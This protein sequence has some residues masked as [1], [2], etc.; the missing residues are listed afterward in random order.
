M[1]EKYT[2]D[3]IEVQRI[4]YGKAYDY[5][6]Y[7]A[8]KDPESTKLYGEGAAKLRKIIPKKKRES[9]ETEI[10]NKYKRKSEKGIAD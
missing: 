3:D 7:V 10:D 1:A 9:I 2:A 4:N 5:N 8:N 6:K